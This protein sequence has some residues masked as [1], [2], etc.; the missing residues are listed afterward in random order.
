MLL[1]AKII[2][3][4][5]AGNK[6]VIALMKKYPELT[7][8]CVLINST[9]KDVPSEYRDKAL[10]MS[11]SFK[12]CAK[13]RSVANSMMYN[14]LSDDSFEYVQNPDEAM[15][16]IVTSSEGGTGSGASTVIADY[17]DQVYH[18]PIHF[19]IFT[20]FEDDA[21]GLKNT[22]DLFKE[23]KTNYTVSAISNKKFLE[24]ASGN[25][26]K[27]EELANDK[28]CDDINILL[29]GTIVESTQ[30]IDQSDLQKLDNT[31]GFMIIENISMDRIKNVGDFDK[32]IIDAIDNS[33]SLITDPSCKRFGTI[34]NIKEKNLSFVDYSNKIIKERYG[35]PFEAFSHIQDVHENEYLQIIVSGLKMPV[36]DIE[37]AYNGFVA[38]ASAVDNS[39]DAFFNKSFDTN[40]DSFDTLAG[41]NVMS[42]DEVKNARNSFFK[43]KTAES[44]RNERQP[45][46]SNKIVKSVKVTVDNF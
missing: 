21:R 2:G 29:G 27:A 18:I 26:L 41:N 34:L 30:N 35:A 23:L 3:I 38:S 33:K 7:N 6:A 14:T 19:Y 1:K 25:R 22:V 12:G 15:C 13:E 20:G 8:D 5:A 44:T 28:F 40:V 43:R 11:G 24:E 42:K 37:D 45:D 39:K 10:E 4:G 32:R 9:L 36:E 16:I 17:I 31:P 46:G